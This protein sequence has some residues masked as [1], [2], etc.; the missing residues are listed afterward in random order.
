MG[1]FVGSSTRFLL[2]PDRY[3]LLPG[4]QEFGTVI[5]IFPGVLLLGLHRQG[6]ILI[7]GIALL[8]GGHVGI[9]CVEV[10]RQFLPELSGCLGEA[11]VVVPAPCLVNLVDAARGAVMVDFPLRPGTHA[12]MIES[13]DGAVAA[14][15]FLSGPDDGIGL[16]EPIAIG[17][18]ALEG[19]YRLVHYAVAL[20]V[21]LVQ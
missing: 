15:V 21:H 4:C 19:A 16:G 12:L 2:L 17:N 3:L 13:D 18:H 7:V 9:G 20:G 10:L 5:T 14:L 8:T 1:I 6:I 11:V